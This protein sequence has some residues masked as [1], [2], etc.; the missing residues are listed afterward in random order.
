MSPPGS[1][2]SSDVHELTLSIESSGEV[3]A[4]TPTGREALGKVDLDELHRQM[5]ELFDGWV[6]DKRLKL[7]REFELFGSLMW[8]SLMPTAVEQLF[9]SE[10]QL[11]RQDGVRLRLQLLFREPAA[12]LGRLPWEYTHRPSTQSRSD[13]SLGTSRDLVLSRYMPL[14]SAR[15]SLAPERPPLRLLIAVS[16]PAELGPVVTQEPIEAIKK[17]AEGGSVEIAELPE[18]TLTGLVEAVETHQPHVLHFLGHG[19][20]LPQLQRGEIALLDE[21]RKTALWFDDERFAEVVAQAATPPR[22]VFLHLCE[23]GTS[24]YKADFAGLAPQLVRREVQAV[25]AMQYP[26]TNRTAVSFSTAFYKQLTAGAPVD[27][28]VQAGRW[29]LMMAGKEDTDQLRDF[30]APVLYMRSRDGLLAPSRADGASPVRA[31]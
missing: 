27:N 21:D 5:I 10:L 23:G 11:A 17:L 14:G 6:R 15:G 25:V 24:D 31:T 2:A 12:D 22:L 29:Q 19:Q 20:Y 16:R 1:T 3:R 8:R 9:E 18:A 30:G 4:G 28:A 7:R 26:I 13:L